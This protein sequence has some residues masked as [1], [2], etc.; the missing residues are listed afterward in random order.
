MVGNESESKFWETTEQVGVMPGAENVI[1][2]EVQA[3]QQIP[4]GATHFA[5]FPQTNAI[6]ALV[7]SIASFACG[8]L[9]LS[10]PALFVALSAKKITDGMP[11]HPDRGIA[12]AA[13][14]TAIVNIVLS[15]LLILLYAAT[16]VAYMSAS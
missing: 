3:A 13:Y 12:N 11:T 1:A 7:L 16:V 6:L 4:L 8:G 5:M 14:I 2:G 10:I 9:I 15:V